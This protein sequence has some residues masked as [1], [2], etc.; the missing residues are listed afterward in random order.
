M[1]T[2]QLLIILS[3]ILI[4]GVS[5]Q[6]GTRSQSTPIKLDTIYANEHKNVALFFPSP[7]RQGAVGSENFV[8]SFNR[9]LPQYFGLLQAK[10]GRESNLLIIT[11]D[12]LVYSYIIKY[13]AQISNVNYFIEKQHS[14]GQE[15][16]KRD[17]LTSIDLKPAAAITLSHFK[18]FSTTLLKRKQ[19]LDH[20]SKRRYGIKLTTENI[21]FDQEELYF[22]FEIENK[23][24]LD[25]DVNLLE[26]G[27]ESRTKGKRKS[28]QR[29]L[30]KVR[31]KHQLHEKV[32]KGE[33]VRFVYVLPKFSLSNNS[34]VIVKLQE[35]NG[36][37]NLELKISHRYINNPN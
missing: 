33:C 23:S 19:H 18:A 1:K 4:S 14:I 15:A 6:A 24:G 3:F 25:Y 35:K 2:H 29:I 7:I 36:E 30:K 12:G 17:T 27:V 28:S 13:K 31:Y 5:L 37:R 34:R 8:F 26:V 20:L 32:K 16:S 21:V 22:V 10:P 9:D 11:T